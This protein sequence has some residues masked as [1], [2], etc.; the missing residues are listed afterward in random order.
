MSLF[1]K[2][3]KGAG[4]SKSGLVIA[5]LVL[6]LLGK[7][8]G[9]STLSVL[10]VL[11]AMLL[12]IVAVFWHSSD[13]KRYHWNG[14]I[15]LTS[16]GRGAFNLTKNKFMR[17]LDDDNGKRGMG[18]DE[19]TNRTSR[20]GRDWSSGQVD[21]KNRQR[22]D[23]RFQ[24]LYI[25]IDRDLYQLVEIPKVEKLLSIEAF[26]EI[27]SRLYHKC[28]RDKLFV[29]DHFILYK[30]MY[31]PRNYVVSLEYV[32]Q[33]NAVRLWLYDGYSVDLNLSNSN[34]NDVI[35]L[36][37]ELLVVFRQA[38]IGTCKNPQ[39]LKRLAFQE[40]KRSNY[41]GMWRIL[42]KSYYN[43]KDDNHSGSPLDEMDL[44]NGFH[45]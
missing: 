42:G 40:I 7:I 44:F 17:W 37:D 33:C 34:E 3:N 38:K 26:T 23:Y 14:A 25:R 27:N 21:S 16:I 6:L 31:V 4:Y 5:A 13:S 12:I 9:K 15:R 28:V 11:F 22:I 45:R 19:P 8:I 10:M 35:E 39:R 18:R 43:V 24:Y 41:D 2:F 36:L 29:G 30:K 1:S 32:Q 20:K